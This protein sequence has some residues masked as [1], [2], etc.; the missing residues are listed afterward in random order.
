MVEAEIIDITAK[1]A[2]KVIGAPA[3]QIIESNELLSLNEY[4][5]GTL[6]G[7]KKH[8]HSGIF[9]MGGLINPKWKGRLTIEF[10]LYGIAKIEEGDEVA[11]AIIVTYDEP[12]KTTRNK[13]KKKRNASIIG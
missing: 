1:S 13:K 12:V 10:L 11:H 8:H 5:I 7:K 6:E 4:Q 9:M 3:I 2:T